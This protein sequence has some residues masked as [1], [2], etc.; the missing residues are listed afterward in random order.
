MR[1]ND[2]KRRG[3]GKS[4]KRRLDMIESDMRAVGEY[5]GDVE[6][7]DKWKSG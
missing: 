2:V 3:R 5:V 1:I 6:N 4:E 7:R